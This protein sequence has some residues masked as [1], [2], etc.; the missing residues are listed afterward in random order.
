MTE[1]SANKKSTK[2]TNGVLT[3][4]FD[5]S[6]TRRNV[7]QQYEQAHFTPSGT[8]PEQEA[9]KHFFFA[10]EHFAKQGIGQGPCTLGLMVSIYFSICFFFCFLFFIFGLNF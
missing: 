7:P 5:V 4:H 2:S 6:E 8:N 1:T 9:P 3:T 10:R